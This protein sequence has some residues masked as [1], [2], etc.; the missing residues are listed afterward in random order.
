MVTCSWCVLCC[1]ANPARCRTFNWFFLADSVT[2]CHGMHSD[3]TFCVRDDRS[4][5]GYGGCSCLQLASMVAAAARGQEAR[6]FQNLFQEL[7]VASPGRTLL[8]EDG[9]SNKQLLKHILWPAVD[10]SRRCARRGSGVDPCSTQCAHHS[11]GNS[12][13]VW[14][15][16]MAELCTARG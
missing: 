6:K 14:N 9:R 11:S 15:P 16:L 12:P 3:V 1:Q 5:G 13:D 4:S 10:R 8:R 7:V 2:T